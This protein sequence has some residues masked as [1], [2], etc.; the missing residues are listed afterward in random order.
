MTDINNWQTKMAFVNRDFNEHC[1]WIEYH[2]LYHGEENAINA[3]PLYKNALIYGR[4]SIVYDTGNA[5]MDIDP[6]SG[7]PAS[8]DPASGDPAS[9]LPAFASATSKCIRIPLYIINIIVIFIRY[10]NR[11]CNLLI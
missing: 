4:N 3:F 10:I 8:G 7:D 6:A 9:G 1:D 11:P 5:S 2:D